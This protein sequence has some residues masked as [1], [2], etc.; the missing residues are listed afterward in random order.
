[1]HKL[2]GS[3]CKYQN[4][5]E[6]NN[7]AIFEWSPSPYLNLSQQ[8]VRKQIEKN[9]NHGKNN[10]FHYKLQTKALINKKSI[11]QIYSAATPLTMFTI[12]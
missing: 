8:P 9:S 7:A 2:K 10:N 11:S 5:D 12:N 4:N 3:Q 1:L 6:V